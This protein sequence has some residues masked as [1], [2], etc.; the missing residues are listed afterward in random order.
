MHSYSD[1]SWAIFQKTKHATTI[2][3]S[4]CNIVHLPQR[5]KSLHSHKNLYM[6]IYRSFFHDGPKLE[7]TQM[8]FNLWMAKQTI[9]HTYY[10]ILLS[11]KKEWT[12][13]TCNNLNESLENYTERKKSQLQKITYC[14]IPFVYHAWNNRIIEM[15]P[16]GGGNALYL[17]CEGVDVLAVIS[18]YSF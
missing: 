3:P 15:V 6:N 10:R 14:M 7:A 12:A 13:D 4:N 5:N 16:C 2:K 17:H 8:S 18:Q 9:V 1:N 11:N